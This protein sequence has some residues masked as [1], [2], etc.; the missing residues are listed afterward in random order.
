M[1]AQAECARRSRQAPATEIGLL[2]PQNPIRLRHDIFHLRQDLVLEHRVI[3][4]PRIERG[5]AAD[6]SVQI[7]E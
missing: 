2:I 1:R 6:G 5:D 4:D 3:T 7:L